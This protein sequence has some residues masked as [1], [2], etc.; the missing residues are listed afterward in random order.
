MELTEERYR[1]LEAVVNAGGRLDHD[2]PR[3]ADFCSA[4]P[5][6]THPDVL[7]QCHDAGWLKTWHDDRTDASLVELTKEGFDL[8]KVKANLFSG[9]ITINEARRA[10]GLAP[11]VEGDVRLKPPLPDNF[12]EA[13]AELRRRSDRP[14]QDREA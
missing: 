1:C 12:Q 11:I 10:F 4:A 5:T 6:L 14:D 8:V 3:L 7:H 2:D 9:K 13:G